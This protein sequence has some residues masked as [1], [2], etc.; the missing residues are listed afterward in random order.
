MKS[1][2]LALCL[3]LC[4]LQIQGGMF[5]L[6]AI[7][8]LFQSKTA[9]PIDTNMFAKDLQDLGDALEKLKY[10]DEALVKYLD[11]IPRSINELQKQFQ[12]KSKEHK[13]IGTA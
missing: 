8:K 3:L 6:S 2:L 4:V 12:K 1:I 5:K 7:R 11:V 9:D 10:H 13:I